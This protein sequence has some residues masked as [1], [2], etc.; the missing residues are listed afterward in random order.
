M[1]TCVL[2]SLLLFGAITQASALPVPATPLPT[3]AEVEVAG[4]MPGPGLWQVRRD[5]HV[6]WLIGSLSPVPERMQWQ[7]DELDARLA[8]ADAILSTPSFSVSTGRGRLHALTLLPSALGARKLPDKQ[9]LADVLAPELHARWSV[10]KAEHIGR[11][12]G[13]E[14]WRPLF[15]AQKLHRKVIE[16]AGLSFES[17][18]GGYVDKAAKG[19]KLPRIPV[20]LEFTIGD[21]RQALKEFKQAE[22]DDIDCFERTLQRLEGDVTLLSERARAWATGDVD[23][24]RTLHDSD[25]ASACIGALVNSPVLRQRGVDELL[26][27]AQARWVDAAERTLAERRTTVGVVPMAWLLADEG[28]LATLTARGYRV[29]GPDEADFDE[30]TGPAAADAG[31]GAPG[32]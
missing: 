13:I 10:L 27:Q 21:S 24:L 2:A 32:S 8:E 26:A 9:T 16:R 1:R 17:P 23:A 28:I 7:S 19:R 14:R 20:V 11:D 12:R 4:V 15:A 18:V 6:L 22:L 31:P 30:A 5:E 29:I 3:L 25:P